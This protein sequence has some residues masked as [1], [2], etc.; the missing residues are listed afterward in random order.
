VSSIERTLRQAL[1]QR[2]SGLGLAKKR[3]LGDCGVG[4][5]SRWTQRTSFEWPP[6][7]PAGGN[8]TRRNRHHE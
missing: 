3:G 8:R 5:A 7:S 1:A 6:H 4:T 2:F